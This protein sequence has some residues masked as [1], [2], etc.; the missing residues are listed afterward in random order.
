[1]T[2][3]TDTNH[4]AL[5]L[6]VAAELGD[7]Q[8]WGNLDNYD[9]ELVNNAIEMEMQERG[10]EAVLDQDRAEFVWVTLADANAAY[11]AYV[12]AMKARRLAELDR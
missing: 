7:A 4:T 5:T 10:I 6:R 8:D 2:E 11:D 12:G 3:T 1:M 9:G